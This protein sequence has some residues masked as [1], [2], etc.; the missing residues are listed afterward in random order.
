MNF[1]SFVSVALASLS[2]SM[3]YGVNTV[4]EETVFEE[5][6]TFNKYVDISNQLLV[7]GTNGITYFSAANNG[8]IVNQ[9]FRIYNDL[10]HNPYA[11]LG[12][13][14]LSDDEG[15]VSWEITSNYTTPSSSAPIQV[16][17]LFS[18]GQFT[19]KG[20][21]FLLTNPTEGSGYSTMVKMTKEGDV[22]ASSLILKPDSLEAFMNPRMMFTYD[23][24][25]SSWGLSVEKY[26]RLENSPAPFTVSASQFTLNNGDLIV[27]GKIEC[28]KTLKVAE[29]D[30]KSLR[31]NDVKVDLNNAADYVF[32]ENYDLKSLSEVEAYVK[33]NKHLP[34]VP[35]ATE[36]K[37]EGMSVSEMTN[38]LLEK[39]EE[40][41]LHL[42][43]VEKE[44]QALKA[45][46][47]A[48]KK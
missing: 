36:L 44:N 7:K 9:Y 33:A 41:T 26:G 46:I 17:I 5:H 16:P 14:G 32:D 29:A 13:L 30:V 39:V 1:K 21:D 40:L 8:A 42:I 48:L 38:L 31:A 22:Y 11:K 28:Q 19:F 4:D 25:A 15:N 10:E 23:K 47:E 6:V 2:A 24:E 35:S 3:V 27:N 43:R 37:S 12:F 45:E 18:A 34:G 20:G